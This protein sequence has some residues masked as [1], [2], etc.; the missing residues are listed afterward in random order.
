MY[1]LTSECSIYMSNNTNIT[2]VT[3]RPYALEKSAFFK[4][5]LG[6]V[7]RRGWLILLLVLAVILV[8]TWNYKDDPQQVIFTSVIVVLL[9]GGS[10][11]YSLWRYVNRKENQAFYLTKHYV[12][13]SEKISGFS[14]DGSTV[15]YTIKNLF[16]ARLVQEHYF[17][18]VS[19]VQQI[20]IPATAFKDAEDRA[21]FETHVIDKVKSLRAAA[22]K[23]LTAA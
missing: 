13:D 17:L 15:S 20:I 18:Y 2:S 23:K 4:L 3:T 8:N 6:Q 1:I 16:R 19:R 22:K 11:L 12:I 9:M 5:L 21:W 10:I 7:A 14:E